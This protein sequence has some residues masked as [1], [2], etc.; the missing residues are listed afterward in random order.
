MYG[1]HSPK[2]TLAQD[3]LTFSPKGREIAKIIS[4]IP[5]HQVN[6]VFYKYINDEIDVLKM[7]ER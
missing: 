5:L 2:T 4:K 1:F 3:Y 7:Y 6:R